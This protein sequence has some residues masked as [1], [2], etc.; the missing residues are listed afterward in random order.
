MYTVDSTLDPADGWVVTFR[1]GGTKPPLFFIC[2]A[3]GDTLDYSDIAAALTDDQP[4]YG[5]GVPPL[6]LGEAFPTVQRLAA[7]YVDEVRRRQPHGPYRLCGH[8]FG[9]L[10]VYEM[11]LQLAKA[12]DKASLVALI[13]TVHPGFKR[14]LSTRQRIQFQVSYVTSRT[15]GYAHDLIRGRLGKIAM[16][17]CDSL[18]S[19]GKRL[20]WKA[21]RAVFGQLDWAPP[22]SIKSDE[23]MLVGA[24][25]R[26]DPGHY[27]GRLVLLNAADR[28]P[29][30]KLDET[31]G[32]RWC[33]SGTMDIHV[34]PGDHFTIMHEPNATALARQIEPY[35]TGR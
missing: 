2:A 16:R 8:S 11:T 34:I 28:P 4:V 23:L 12:G 5:F 26:Y 14:N 3:G 21:T 29:E 10:V 31:L 27:D 33:T 1:S 13:D 24:W 30:Y 17:A 35:L 9:G 19:R 25:H 20:F 6:D 22:P 15:A 32:W 18:H 7:I